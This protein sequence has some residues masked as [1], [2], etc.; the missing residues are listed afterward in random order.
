MKKDT[1][2]IRAELVNKSL[3][4]IFKYIDTNITLDE[5]A[6]LNS[7]SKY[8]FHRIFKEETGEN[9]FERITAIR[10]QKAANLLIT[11]QYS[12]ISE[13]AQLC[14]YSSHSSFIKAFKNRF[15]FTPTQWKKGE[16]LS[17]SKN[18]LSFHEK[19]NDDFFNINPLIK[20]A[21][22]RTCAYIRHKGYDLSVAKTWERLMAF[23][24]EKKLTNSIQIGIFH[25]NPVIT[26]YQECHYVASIQVNSEFIPTNSISKL[27]IEESLCAVFHYDGV[28][29]DAV[30]LLVYIYN[31]WM[32]SSGYEAK[33]LPLYA[34][35]HKN[36]F[37][38]DNK[39]FSM[40]FYV[41]IRI[42]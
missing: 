21:P 5:L 13:I 17:Y 32:P 19:I 3:T 8:H 30:N 11:N 42:V 26:P 12:S 28:Y 7:V 14:G 29:G 34:I 22:K 20:I 10:L 9:L 31:F 18:I 16:Y 38:E 27:E 23:A 15:T 6:K 41:P 2:H 25:D 33:T 37:L 4:Y 40:D 1:K 35:Y 24:Y 39:D 36:H